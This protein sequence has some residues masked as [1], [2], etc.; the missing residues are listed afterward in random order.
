MFSE[1]GLLKIV[2]SPTHPHSRICIRICIFNFKK[3]T[4]KKNRNTKK[5]KEAKEEK[6]ISPENQLK[7]K[8]ATAQVK[9]FLVSRISGNKS[10]FFGLTTKF[11]TSWSVQSSRI[12][13]EAMDYHKNQC[14][15]PQESI[16]GPLLFLI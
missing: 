3:Q 10:F 14:G 9:I 8:L 7:K 6:I 2:L 16:L 1:F 12:V 4:S 15:V 5:A 13:F 11:M